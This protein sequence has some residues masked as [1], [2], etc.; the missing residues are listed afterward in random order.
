MPPPAPPGLAPAWPLL[1]PGAL[2]PALVPAPPIGLPPVLLPA[3]ALPPKDAPAELE[4][5]ELE[6]AELEPA[7]PATLPAPLAPESVVGSSPPQPSAVNM[8]RAATSRR[9]PA[10]ASPFR[11]IGNRSQVRTHSHRKLFDI[12]LPSY[13]CSGGLDATTSRKMLRVTRS[14]LS[15]S[16]RYSSDACVAAPAPSRVHARAFSAGLRKGCAPGRVKIVSTSNRSSKPDDPPE[17]AHGRP[18]RGS[19]AASA[20]GLPNLSGFRVESRGGRVALP[21]LRRNLPHA[22]VRRVAK[23]ARV[24]ARLLGGHGARPSRPHADALHPPSRRA[25]WAWWSRPGSPTSGAPTCESTHHREQK[26]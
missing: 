8:T 12:V 5:A 23:D 1:P 18:S 13:L 16:S 15:P 9:R 20:A 26:R 11:Y 17:R 6:P 25:R 22:G 10:L 3:A 4:P 7:E 24:V 19:A 21:E 2:P 14:A